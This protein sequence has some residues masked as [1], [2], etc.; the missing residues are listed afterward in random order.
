MAIARAI[1]KQPGEINVDLI[2]KSLHS[3]SGLLLLDE[4]TSALDSASEHEVVWR[5]SRVY[6]FFWELF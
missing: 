2:A 6:L 1:I 5:D 4:A 3:T